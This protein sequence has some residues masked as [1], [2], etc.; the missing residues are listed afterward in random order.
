[1][2]KKSKNSQIDRLNDVALAV[3]KRDDSGFWVLSTGQQCYVA[4]AASRLDLLAEMGYTVPEALARLDPGW[5]ELL[6]S[7]W[8]HAGNPAKYA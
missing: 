4:L 5:I 2:Y 8:E 1:M 3:A 7:S 6:I